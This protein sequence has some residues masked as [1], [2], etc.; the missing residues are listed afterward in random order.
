M[1]QQFSLQANC[2]EARH[3][4]DEDLKVMLSCTWAASRRQRISGW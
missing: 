2:K 1:I 4:G 3:G